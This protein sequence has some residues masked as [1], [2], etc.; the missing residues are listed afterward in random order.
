MADQDS[1]KPVRDTVTRLS[2]PVL[3]EQTKF[4]KTGTTEHAKEVN[5]NVISR[6]SPINVKKV[7][8]GAQGIDYGPV[9]AATVDGR[10]SMA[11]V[12]EVAPVMAARPGDDAMIHLRANEQPDPP[13]S[14]LIQAEPEF[15]V[16]AAL[17][18]LEKAIP[19]PI[20]RVPAQVVTPVKRIKVQFVG[21]TFGKTTV[22]CAEAVVSDTVIA[23]AYDIASASAIVEPPVASIDDELIVKITDPRTNKTEQFQVMSSQLTFEA[24][25]LLWIVLVKLTPEDL[26][27]HK[28][29]KG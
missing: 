9:E 18:E 10:S 7:R 16:E 11:P 8:L 25:G 20:V 23:L 29:S 3:N 15:P 24:Q 27:E 26:A 21:R 28:Q 5:A 22:F 17:A 4:K 19:G 1:A 6:H 13:R 12:E 14:T 2:S